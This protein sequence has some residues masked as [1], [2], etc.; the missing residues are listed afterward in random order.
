MNYIEAVLPVSMSEMQKKCDGTKIAC[1]YN[2]IY[3]C[4]LDKKYS[5]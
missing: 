4:A 1:L 3:A 5:P 2:D